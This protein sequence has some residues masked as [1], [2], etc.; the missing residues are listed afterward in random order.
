MFETT[1][2]DRRDTGSVDNDGR[3]SERTHTFRVTLAVALLVV[4]LAG[5]V[6]VS[7]PAMAHSGGH[8]DHGDGHDNGETAPDWNTSVPCNF[9]NPGWRDAQTIVGVDI[10]ASERCRP[11]NPNVVAAS[12]AGTNNVGMMML[13]KSG[14][15]R[16]AVDAAGRRGRRAPAGPGDAAPSTNGTRRT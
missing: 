9:E 3:E 7:G 11:D 1:T 12:V 14:L 4:V 10:Q 13:M 15:A 5:L 16:D 8:D 2:V 6:A